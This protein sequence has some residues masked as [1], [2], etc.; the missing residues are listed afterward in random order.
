MNASS[1]PIRIGSGSTIEAMPA[2]QQPRTIVISGPAGRTEDGDVVARLEA[3]GLEGGA[4]GAGL[5]VELA[6][7]DE[8]GYAAGRHRGA[9]EADAG[10]RVRRPF[11]PLDRRRREVHDTRHATAVER[12]VPGPATATGAGGSTS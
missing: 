1:D 2:I 7:R 11:E 9:D 5:V 12:P 6:P 3:A 8:L 4:D 10:R